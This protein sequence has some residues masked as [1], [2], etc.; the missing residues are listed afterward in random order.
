MITLHPQPRNTTL[1]SIVTF[2]C[3][4]GGDN[5]NWII[6]GHF[7][8]STNPALDP[9][10]IDVTT[11]DP[12]SPLFSTLTLR[13]STEESITVQCVAISLLGANDL[14]NEVIVLVQGNIRMY[15]I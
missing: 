7:S 11:T 4:G 6:N 5:L 10:E 14:S 3:S 9:L 1:G 2:T 8:E 15:L 13:S 12:P